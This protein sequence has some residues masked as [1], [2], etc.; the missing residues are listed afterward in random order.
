M[1]PSFPCWPCTSR[2]YPF[3]SD[4]STYHKLLRTGRRPPSR[5]NNF[6]CKCLHIHRA[7]APARCKCRNEIAE[8]VVALAGP[9]SGASSTTPR[10]LLVRRHMEGTMKRFAH[11]A[12]CRLSV[13]RSCG[14]SELSVKIDHIRGSLSSRRCDRRDRARGWAA[15]FRRLG[16]IDHHREQGRRQYADWRELRGQVAA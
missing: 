4:T 11:R 8:T 16:P 15:P 13:A 5:G 10:M 3:Y 7:F 1:V 2:T 9:S 12:R 14:C 6:E